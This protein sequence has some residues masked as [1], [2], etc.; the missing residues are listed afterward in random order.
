MEVF[1]QLVVQDCESNDTEYVFVK[2]CRHNEEYDGDDEDKSR[3]EIAHALDAVE[4]LLIA[5]NGELTTF[6]L[7]TTS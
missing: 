5:K 3:R 1:P 6:R 4:E 2:H 7:D